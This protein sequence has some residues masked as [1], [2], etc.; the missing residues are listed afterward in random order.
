MLPIRPLFVVS[1]VALGLLGGVACTCVTCDDTPRASGGGDQL[2]WP[3]TVATL[4]QRIIALHATADE[5]FV[6]SDHEFVRLSSDLTTVESRPL[7]AQLQN[8]GRPAVN[9]LVY[10]RVARNISTG[11]ELLQVS[12]AQN[13]AASALV[14]ID[15]LTPEPLEVIFDGETVGAFNREGTIYIQPVLRRDS[16]LVALAR[17]ELE[18]DQT[19]TRIRELR[20]TGLIDLPEVRDLERVVS[21]VNYLE[22]AFYVATKFGAYRVSDAGQVE[23]L[24]PADAEIRDVFRYDG[25]FYA[26]QSSAGPMFTSRDGRAW[27][28][29]G[30]ATNL[31]LVSPL[32]DSLIVSHEVE[33]WLWQITPDLERQA[34]PLEL[35]PGFP[36]DNS[37]YFGLVRFGERFYLSVDNRLYSS[38]RLEIEE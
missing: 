11:E 9:D 35:N 8:L 32:G 21:S 12:L 5:L 26:S 28:S 30:I 23:R 34:R 18:T 27:N 37:L 4:R 7:V 1:L 15:S 36:L 14:A 10:A 20:F 33:G 24:T 38:D 25:A 16:R 29:S 13:A 3:D 6:F 19:F 22:G 2:P 17:F 31:R